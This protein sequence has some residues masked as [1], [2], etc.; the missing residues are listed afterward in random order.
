MDAGRD[1]DNF[2]ALEKKVRILTQK[3]E[4]S[5]ADRQQLETAS[6]QRERILKGVI[7]EFESSQI[8]LESRSHELEIALGNLKTLQVK[9]IESEKMSALGILVAGIAHEINN[10][11]NFIYSNLDYAHQYFQDL[12]ALLELYQHHYPTPVPEIDQRIAA[13][14][15]DFLQQDL[16]KL[17]QSMRSGTERIVDIVKS[18]RTFSRLDEATLKK[19]DLHESIDSIVMILNCQLQPTLERPQGIHLVREYG[20]LPLIECYASQLNQVIMNLLNNAIYALGEAHQQ[21]T[22]AARIAN[23]STIWIRTTLDTENQVVIAILD[24]GL[25]IPEDIHPKLFDPFF[26]TKPV[27]KGTGLGLSICH[28]IVTQLH[29]GQLNFYSTSGQPTE[30]VIT[31]PIAALGRD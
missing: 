30:F 21:R 22:P 17:L 31:L 16:S 11:I 23:P 6:E 24:N 3:L 25:G 13:I 12:L 4:R 10:P 14:D 29:R 19:I 27:G 20:Q 1:A 9:L 7:R 26:T 8:A 2:K 28:Q 5:E 15:L 18:F